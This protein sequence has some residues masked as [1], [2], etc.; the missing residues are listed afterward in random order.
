[1]PG[2]SA[3]AIRRYF[4]ELSKDFTGTA[5]IGSSREAPATLP[6]ARSSRNFAIKTFDR[7]GGPVRI[8]LV[9]EDH[10]QTSVNPLPHLRAC[11]HNADAIVRTDL[12]P[13]V[14]RIPVRYRGE[15]FVSRQ[16]L[17]HRCSG[18]P[19]DHR[20]EN[21]MTSLQLHRESF[22]DVR[23]WRA[24]RGACDSAHSGGLTSGTSDMR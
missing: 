11:D 15:G 3:R 5:C 12:E 2:S 21:E 1:M 8:E 10:R 18:P 13:T 23:N 17:P 6:C 20:A 14:E 4:F 22:L 7:H 24:A 9:C 16:V 19:H